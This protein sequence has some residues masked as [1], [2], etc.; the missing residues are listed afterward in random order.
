M[1]KY[2]DTGVAAYQLMV[3]EDSRTSK[4]CRHLLTASGYGMILP[5][6]HPFWKKYGFPGYHINCRT[7]IAPVYPSMIG[8][9]GYNVDNPSMK[10]LQKFKP[11]EGFG[12]NPVDK[13]SWWR[14][15]KD[16]A[17]RAAD[18][19]I[20]EIIEKYAKDNGLHNF[21][22]DL[23][24]G[25]DTRKL[26]GTLF[27]AEKAKLA[28]PE[29][30]EIEVARIL[31]ENKHSFYFTPKV[32]K[33]GVKSPDGILDG[34]TTDIKVLTS[35]NIYKIK[36]RMLECNAQKGRICCIH[37]K[38]TS[39]YSQKRAIDFI[40]LLLSGKFKINDEFVIFDKINE[41]CLIYGEEIVFIKK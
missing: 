10:S 31:K 36:D 41:V 3:V 11:Q 19:G 23:V 4:I 32:E 5:V 25:S 7:S 28:D 24:D 12:G 37:L 1:Q 39:G 16:M 20:W 29:Q 8:K 15:T 17:F 33:H 9:Y 34:K 27:K 30:K 26:S 18:L 21:A 14:M 2:E 35:K 38:D 40:R 22:L 13:E 6:D